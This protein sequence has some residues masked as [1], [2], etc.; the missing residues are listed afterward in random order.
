MISFVLADG[1]E[2][3]R[4]QADVADRADAVPRLGDGDAVA[5]AAPPVRR[6]ASICGSSARDERPRVRRAAARATPEARRARRPSLL[7]RRRPPSA[8]RPAPPRRASTRAVSSSASSIRSSIV[9]SSV[10]ISLCAKRDLVLDGVVLLVGLHRHRLLAELREA[11]LVHGDV[12]LD[13][14]PRV[15]VLGEPLLGGRDFL[16]RRSSRASSAVS[17][18]GSSASRRSAS[19]AAESSRW[20]AMRRSRSAFIGHA[21]KQKAR[22]SVAPVATVG[23]FAR[24]AA[25]LSCPWIQD[26]GPTRIRTWNRPVMSRRL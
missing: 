25:E 12:L 22:R 3:L 23:A 1:V 15:L 4:P 13:G 11:A 8:R 16:A 24:L 2:D 26:G 9:S 18:S 19:C 5:L 6:S 14:A 17:R 20:S 10:L 21:P 7:R